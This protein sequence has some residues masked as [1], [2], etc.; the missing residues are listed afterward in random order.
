MTTPQE[1]EA[2]LVQVA[3]RKAGEQAHPTNPL[4]VEGTYRSVSSLLRELSIQAFPISFSLN[5]HP[6][7]SQHHDPTNNL[8]KHD[9]AQTPD[10]QP[11][12]TDTLDDFPDDESLPELTD[13]MQI[14]IEIALERRDE[15]CLV[16]KPEVR[17][18][19]RDLRRLI[20][21]AKVSRK[22]VGAY[23]WLIE[24]RSDRK[25]GPSVFALSPTYTMMLMSRGYRFALSKTYQIDIFSY[26]LVLCPFNI[27]KKDW[28]VIIIDNRSRTVTHCNSTFGFFPGCME[29]VRELI[30]NEHLAIRGGYPQSYN[31]IIKDDLPHRT[32]QTDSGLF[33]CMYAEYMCRNAPITFTSADM[34]YFRR[35]M[36]FEILS[37]KLLT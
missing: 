16:R 19:V 36:A 25:G 27:L 10:P 20:E 32:R 37:D 2:L 21:D 22:M 33:A 35:K 13:E 6:N 14:A 28:V 1:G 34:W 17:V 31:T 9:P 29:A 12:S 15:V 30:Q 4:K 3:T 18:K 26:D 5:D 11:E 8:T 24:E 23:L 7:T